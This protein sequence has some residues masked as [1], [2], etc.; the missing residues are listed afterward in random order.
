MKIDDVKK[1]LNK[2]NV[3]LEEDNALF[4]SE[5]NVLLKD[6]FCR[7][8]VLKNSLEGLKDVFLH[9]NADKSPLAF[10][11][12]HPSKSESNLLYNYFHNYLKEEINFPTNSGGIELFIH[13]CA[14]N[15]SDEY[16]IK[17]LKSELLSFYQYDNLQRLKYFYYDNIEVLIDVFIENKN[18]FSKEEKILMVDILDILYPTS[19]SEN[20]KNELREYIQNILP[21]FV[22]R[23]SHLF[24]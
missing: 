7:S 17:L 23:F 20:S 22:Q 6:D 4:V 24:K 10:S 15:L 2:T 5:I 8:L 21:F 12:F 3:L 16:I 9:L 18:T 11:M 1:W 13:C 19:L 14:K